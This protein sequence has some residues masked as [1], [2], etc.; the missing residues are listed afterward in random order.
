MKTF[1]DYLSFA[2][3]AALDAEVPDE[4]L[5]L[6]IMDNAAMMAHMSADMLGLQLWN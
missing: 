6:T 1:E 3:V 4:L 2:T 5:P